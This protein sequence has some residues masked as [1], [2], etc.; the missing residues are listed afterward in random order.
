MAGLAAALTAIWSILDPIAQSTVLW[1]G[2]PIV[3]T[4]TVLQTLTMFFKLIRRQHGYQ[5]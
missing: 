4:V 2:W 3:R 1:I 5:V